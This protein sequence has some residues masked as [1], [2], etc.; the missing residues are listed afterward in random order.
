ME[1]IPRSGGQC[2]DAECIRLE[3]ALTAS[4]RGLVVKLSVVNLNICFVIRVTIL[5]VR[6]ASQNNTILARAELARDRRRETRRHH[7][8]LRSCSTA[9]F[10]DFNSNGLLKN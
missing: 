3:S 7:F 10:R 1:R 2:F 5:S 9:T 4:D 6:A 8:K